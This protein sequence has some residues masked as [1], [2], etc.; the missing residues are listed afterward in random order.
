MSVRHALLL[1]TLILGTLATFAA[2]HPNLAKGFQPDKIYQFDGVENVNL[3]NGN[4]S[5]TIPLGQQYKGNGTLAYRFMASYNSKGWDRRIIEYQ[6]GCPDSDPDLCGK[7]YLKTVP[8]R[9]SNA[10]MGWLVSLGSLLSPSDPALDPGEGGGVYELYWTYESPSGAQH[11]FKALDP[12]GAHAYTTDGSFLRWRD[13]GGGT[14]EVHFPDGMV[15]S[16][17]KILSKDPSPRLTQIRDPYGNRLDIIYHLNGGW[18]ATERDVNG[19]TIRTHHVRFKDMTTEPVSPLY[20]PPNYNVVVDEVDLAAFDG[21][22]AVYSF[23]YTVDTIAY[24]GCGGEERINGD[25]PY[26]ST[27]TPDPRVPRLNTITLPD[28]STWEFDYHD[29]GCDAI[30][31]LVY[32]T[33]A[34]TE[35]T[36]GGWAMNTKGCHAPDVEGSE[37]IQDPFTATEGV[38]SKIVTIPGET[39]TANWTY[40]QTP[41]LTLSM[42]A[43]PC[44]QPT[45]FSLKRQE[46][47]VTVTLTQDQNVSQTR[48]FFSIWPYPPGTTSLFHKSEYG[49]PYTRDKGTS[50]GGKCIITDGAALCLS[51]EQY[52]WEGGAWV[53]KRSTYVRYEGD[54]RDAGDEDDQYRR[55]ADSLTFFHDDDD[56]N[57]NDRWVKTM[58]TEYDGLG[59]FRKVTTT[60]SWSGMTGLQK[61]QTTNYN[62]GKPAVTVDPVTWLNTPSNSRP[63]TTDKWFLSHFDAQT[64]TENGT[65]F[66]TETC[67]DAITGFLKR[68]RTLAGATRQ[69]NDLL[70]VFTKDATGNVG[71]ESHYGGDQAE[72]AL[73]QAFLSDTCASDPS[74]SP[75]Y[76]ITHTYS[77]GARATSKYDAFTFKILDLTIDSN[78]GFPS[79]SRDTAGLET[80]YEFNSMGRLTA[81]LPPSEAWTQYSYTN[82]SGTLP[83]SVAVK[84]WP[85]GGAAAGTPLT[86]RRIYF[87]GLGRPIQVRT[88]MPSDGSTVNWSVV[89][90]TYDPIGRVIQASMPEYRTSGDY[91]Q[92]FSPLAVTT[93][94]YD[95]FNRPL[96]VTNPDSKTT[97]FTY[98]GA[99]KKVRSVNVATD[100]GEVAVTTTELVDG[101]G[102]LR[103]VREN[104]VEPEP[105]PPALPCLSECVETSYTYDAADRLRS[106]TML[107]DGKSQSR[108]FNYDGRGFLTSETHPE[109]GTTAYEYDSRGHVTKRD[110][111]GADLTFTYDGAERLLEIKEGS[112]VVKKYEYDPTGF[113]GRLKSTLRGND[114]L[115]LGGNVQVKETHSYNVDT[116]RLSSKATQV[117]GTTS[118][119]GASFTDGYTYDALGALAS[120]T[121]PQC[122]SG[123]TGLSQPSRTVSH[124]YDQGMLET[125]TGYADPIA[126]HANGM[127]KSVRH[128]SLNLSGTLV[129]GPLYEQTLDNSMPRPATISVS[130]FCANFLVNTQPASQTIPSGQ[131]VTLTVSVTGATAYQW[132]EGVNTLISGATSSSLTRS[133]A[134]TT[135][136]WVRASN[137]SCTVDSQPATITVSSCPAPVINSVTSI[138]ASGTAQASVS[139][140]ANGTYAWT[141]T[142]GTIIGSATGNSINF[143]AGCSGTVRLDVAVNDCGFDT[144]DV[145]ITPISIALSGTATIP[146]GDSTTLTAQLDGTSP[147]TVT[148]SPGPVQNNVTTTSIQQEVTPNAT[149]T[150]TAT[151]ADA[152]GCN[153]TSN[154][155]T[156]TVTPP[157]PTALSAI[158]T[159]SNSVLVTWAYSGSADHFAIDRL[160][161]LPGGYQQVGT[162]ANGT[163]MSWTNL[164]LPANTAYLYRV[165]A[166]KGG[167]SSDP[168]GF[169]L[170]TTTIFPESIIA[171]ATTVKASHLLE[172]RT[173]VNAVRALASLG[174]ATFTDPSPAGVLIKGVH[175]VELRSALDAARSALNLPTAFYE[176][177]PL[178]V[179]HPIRAVHLLNLRGGVQ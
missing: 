126:Y 127:V 120:V 78:T 54:W 83:A 82:A 170:A 86:D 159:A 113:P 123:C 129:N 60:D 10:G 153:A 141:I 65:T 162:T 177:Q 48:H 152:H 39:T 149:T 21:T 16:F 15:H 50:D 160:S 93:T 176:N 115:N 5:L 138:K 69:T 150:Y 26:G 87:D 155:V 111:L 29:I 107:G 135:Q 100:A 40:T 174:S 168:S 52:D 9:R 104:S 95:G 88:R 59:H 84:Q 18:T 173:A 3:Y 140:V 22:R 76:K 68:Q 44:P 122:T 148:W 169:D 172:L 79:A 62:P 161:S 23:G 27:E 157:A 179:G 42:S 7:Y 136:Y 8:S 85:Y 102:R 64:A 25:P 81:S 56:D 121:Y 103:L 167:T 128:K 71:T 73:P 66:E 154:A 178:P 46:S 37:V 47:R 147:W 139:L 91:L 6:E 38:T 158:A 130:N 13:A 117:I 32:P 36:Y 58:R 67:F 31:S 118:Y 75:K 33:K 99:R 49:L 105:E 17:T 101:L 53:H 70:V 163:T 30:R 2:E 132:Y 156:V 134:A 20:A 171:G 90:T 137:G 175:I 19:V 43:P 133:P 124:V 94:T 125:V 63:G 14:Y 164:S 165:R 80:L 110:S 41:N 142:G 35:W 166:V 4:V 106:V 119:D 114:H 151:I 77:S 96:V 61:I 112:T 108:T 143:R 57:D 98:A 1:A 34:T 72:A 12:S 51:T 144:H 92:S 97:T 145:S 116:G 24:I 109:S 28:G 89:K 11:A 55:E 131:E 45:T 146:Q 74:T